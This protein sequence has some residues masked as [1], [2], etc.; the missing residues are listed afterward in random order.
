[1]SWYVGYPSTLVRKGI[2]KEELMS[3]VFNMMIDTLLVVDSGS[4]L[5]AL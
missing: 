5:D 4:Y 1:M 2:S 3:V